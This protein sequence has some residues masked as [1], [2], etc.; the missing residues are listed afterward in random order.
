MIAAI[1]ARRIDEWLRGL[2]VGPVT[3]NTF[4]RRLAVLFSF[5]KRR[6]YVTENPVVD[7]ERAKE[8][9]TE[10]EILSVNETAHLLES[11][12]SD[13]LPFWA[14]GAFA[15]LRRAEIERLS[16]SEID[17]DAHV[18]ELKASKS[19][20]AS[21]RLVTMQPNLRAWLAPYRT[22]TGRVCPFNLQRKV[23]DDRERAGLL[24]K[25]PH[26]ALRHSFASYHLARFNDAA[27][28]ALEMGNSPA[29]IFRHYRELVKPKDAK[30]YWGIRPAKKTNVIPFAQLED[31]NRIAATRDANLKARK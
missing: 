31:R 30:H 15:G 1:S 29:I 21:R 3:R 25:W 10:V 12:G 20:T 24:A 17:F 18:I 19:K 4:R 6:G 14:I 22:R 5:A 28:L 2:G 7:V 26:N 23:N 27:K 13:M 8:R 9:E 16:W 11:S